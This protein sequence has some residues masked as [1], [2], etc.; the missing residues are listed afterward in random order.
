MRSESAKLPNQ[1]SLDILNV[2]RFTLL[3]I[4]KSVSTAVQF[5]T[6]KES[7][8]E[9]TVGIVAVVNLYGPSKLHFLKASPFGLV[10]MY[11][12]Q[13]VVIGVVMMNDLLVMK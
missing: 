10:S 1:I 8:V 3:D 4:F 9:G 6:A 13:H 7:S 2:K 5:G 12:K 11:I